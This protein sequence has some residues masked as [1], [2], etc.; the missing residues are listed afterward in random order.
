M[1]F[2]LIL[3]RFEHLSILHIT[4]HAS[5]DS[6]LLEP[7]IASNISAQFRSP[8]SGLQWFRTT[9]GSVSGISFATWHISYWDWL[10]HLGPIRKI[11]QEFYEWVL[12]AN[13]EV[14]ECGRLGKDFKDQVPLIAIKY[15]QS[16]TVTFNIT[17]GF[18][19]FIL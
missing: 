12:A 6:N 17:S 13:S 10:S 11:G 16:R 1:K 9:T 5:D 7:F 18:I 2:Y 15:H 8:K 3:N 4:S 19:N 14:F